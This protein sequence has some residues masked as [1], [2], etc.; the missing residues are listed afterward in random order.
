VNSPRADD[1]IATL[2]IDADGVMQRTAVGWEDDLAAFL[3][4]RAEADG[5]R[6]LAAIRDAEVPTMNGKTDIAESMAGVLREFDVQADVEEVLEMWT[7][8]ERD[9]SMVA[10]V[11]ELRQDRI[12]CCLATNQQSRRARWM[13]ANLGYEDVFDRQFYSC[14]LGLAKPDPAYFTTILEELDAKAS[15]VLFIDDTE[16]NVEGARSAGLNAE[17]FRRHGGRAALEEIL[18]SYVVL[19]R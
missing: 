11:Q 9:L 10:A 4:D 13:R 3:G 18:R 6:F 16:V 17:L 5:E 15:T 2:L 7:R 14:E 19:G 1:L 12:L 8:I